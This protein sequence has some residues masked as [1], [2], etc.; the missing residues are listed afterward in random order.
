MQAP[1]DIYRTPNNGAVVLSSQ[2]N[3]VLNG[4]KV[5]LISD[6]R[7]V[8]WKKRHGYDARIYTNV[9]TS[10]ATPGTAGIPLHP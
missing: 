3:T 1:V 6:G 2:P 4:V 5:R 8:H 7:G 10:I 9:G